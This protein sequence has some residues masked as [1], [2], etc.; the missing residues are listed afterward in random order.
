MYISLPK[1]CWKMCY[2]FKIELFVQN[3]KR[4]VWSKNLTGMNKTNTVKPGGG[5]IMIWGCFSSVGTA[6]LVQLEEIMNSSKYRSILALNLLVPA[7]NLKKKRTFTFQHNDPN[8]TSKSTKEWLL[9]GKIVLEWLNQSPNL[10]P[11]KSV[12]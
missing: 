1:P 10:N 11:N 7:R 4:Y 8:H 3:C 12:R 2:G 5:R 9:L 6:A